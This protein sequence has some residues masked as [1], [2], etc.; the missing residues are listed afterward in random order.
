MKPHTIRR[1]LSVTLLVLTGGATGK[2]QQP[3]TFYVSPDG[4]DAWSG[5]LATPNSSRSDGPFATLEAARSAVRHRG[6]RRLQ[7]ATVRIRGGVWL[8]SS[9]FVLDTADG[10]SPGHAVEWTSY[11]GEVARLAG[12]MRMHGWTRVR[13]S[14]ARAI[15][16]VTARDSV[17][18]TSIP[19]GIELA[20]WRSDG[21]NIR[22]VPP[23][24]VWNGRVLRVA[25]WPDT[26]WGRVLSVDS[27]HGVRIRVATSRLERWARAP[28]AWA[29]GYWRYDWREGFVR[30]AGVDVKSRELL[31]EGNPDG[32]GF[33]AGQRY[34]VLNLLEELSSRGEYWIDVEHRLIYVWPPSDPARAEALLSILTQPVIE[35]T[36]A[37]DL[38]LRGLQFE[39][40]RGDGV[41][42]V[43]GARVRLVSAVV[44]SVGG[45]GIEIRGGVQHVVD[46]VA[47]EDVGEGGVLVDGGDRRT[48]SRS[49]HIVEHTRITRF[50]RWVRTTAPGIDV[51]GVGATVRECEISDGPHVGIWLHGNDHLVENNSLH[52][53]L[54]ETGDAGAIYIGRDWTARGNVIRGNYIYALGPDHPWAAPP[55]LQA[56]YVDDMGSGV[57]ITRNVFDHAQTAIVIGGGRDNRIDENV[58]VHSEPALYIDAR[59]RYWR[60]IAE[61]PNSLW[62][63]LLESFERAQP[64]SSPYR[65]RYPSLRLVL[66]DR[67]GEP[68]GNSF[69]NN[70]VV[71]VGEVRRVGVPAEMIEI[72]GTVRVLGSGE[73]LWLPQRM[74]RFL[75]SLSAAGVRSPQEL[76][77]RGGRRE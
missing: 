59:G 29:L 25:Q 15:L 73:G 35:V 5:R 53:L 31:A 24:L 57:T 4:R 36:G 65:D 74:Q 32:I 62:Q 52:H 28:D 58:I 70:V 51:S 3:Q 27:T 16:P 14:V 44:R 23:E 50:A 41:R 60:S 7:G 63:Y 13:D 69:V 20:R 34:A 8:R 9:S 43:G 66:V 54:L 2:A 61:K 68:V 37:S 33:A 30:L 48:L 75:D 19:L 12:A 17:V 22:P 26:G 67:P 56:V 76:P 6:D 45:R 21:R 46:S 10:G 64:D 38:T 1:L 39:A 18:V 11:A 42:I 49:D 47:I 55:I 71:G 72:R 77:R 40:S